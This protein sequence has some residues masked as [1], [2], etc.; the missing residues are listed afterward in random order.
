MHAGHREGGANTFTRYPEV[1]R[2]AEVSIN[3]QLTAYLVHVR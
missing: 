3:G 1:A 2:C